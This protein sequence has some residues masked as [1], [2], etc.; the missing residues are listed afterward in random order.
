MKAL[1]SSALLCFGLA[2]HAAVDNVSEWSLESLGVESFASHAD[3]PGLRLPLLRQGG[4]GIELIAWEMVPQNPA[5]RLL[6]YE[7]G[8]V[9]TSERVRVIRGMVVDPSQRRVLSDEVVAYLGVDPPFL[10]QGPQPKWS[11][12]PGIL[13]IQRTD[14]RSPLRVILRDGFQK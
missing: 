12:S 8:E 11:W 4:G 10:P 9:G 13:L 6:R 7:A 5:L 2:A 14:R 3:L 1:V